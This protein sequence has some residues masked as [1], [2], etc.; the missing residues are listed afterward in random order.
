[1]EISAAQP[2][3]VAENPM[4]TMEQTFLRTEHQSRAIY[5]I[6]RAAFKIDDNNGIGIGAAGIVD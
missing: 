6:G 5:C 1:M 3:T 2:Q 4:A